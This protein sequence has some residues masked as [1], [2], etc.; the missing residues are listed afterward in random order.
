M[1]RVPQD[2]ATIQ[3]AM[4]SGDEEVVISSGVWTGAGNTNLQWGRTP[5]L[6]RSN[7]GPE[8]CIIDCEGVSYA[9]QDASIV[10]SLLRFLRGVTFINSDR[11]AVRSNLNHHIWFYEDCIFRNNTGGAIIHETRDWEVIK[12]YGIENYA[13]PNEIK[14]CI[15][16]NNTKTWHGAA[17]W[18]Y[19][20]WMKI[21]DS[22]FINNRVSSPGSYGGAFYTKSQGFDRNY[23][24]N[25]LFLNNSAP[26]HG[27]GIFCDQNTRADEV[28][29]CTFTGN[30]SA[31]DGTAIHILNTEGIDGCSLRNNIVWNNLP[32]S[33]SLGRPI[34]SFGLDIQHSDVEGG[35]EGRGN[36]NINPL[37]VDPDNDDYRLQMHSACVDAGVNV[38]IDEDI[39]GR[40]RPY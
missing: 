11:G 27:G 14:G 9:I 18:S 13:G 39:T 35:W 10:S 19:Y 15:F 32:L 31:G 8:N 20:S 16:E 38:G 5:R 1:A 4:D 3:A 12:L 2:Y 7:S 6:I 28:Y 24:H 17:I 26:H 29:H 22:I 25:C 21:S 23:F 36:I 37:F 33:G 30:R 34:K 40:R